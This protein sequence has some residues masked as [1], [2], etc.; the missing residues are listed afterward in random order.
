MYHLLGLQG[1]ATPDRSIIHYSIHSTMKNCKTKIERL[2][3]RNYFIAKTKTD[4]L[5]KVEKFI[6]S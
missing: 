6:K 1:K 2:S 3:L 4:L 5:D